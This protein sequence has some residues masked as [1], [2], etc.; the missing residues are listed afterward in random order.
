MWISCFLIPVELGQSYFPVSVCDSI[1]RREI[2]LHLQFL[3][4]DD[5]YCLEG[6]VLVITLLGVEMIHYDSETLS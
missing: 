1:I 2:H 5:Q 4:Q 6:W 3:L